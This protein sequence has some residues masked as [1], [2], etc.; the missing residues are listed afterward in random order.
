[1]TLLLEVDGDRHAV[2]PLRTLR[3]ESAHNICEAASRRR[4]D[5]YGQFQL[6]VLSRRELK[7]SVDLNVCGEERHGVER[8]L[9]EGITLITLVALGYG[10]NFERLALGVD[11]RPVVPIH[12]GAGGNQIDTPDLGPSRSKGTTDAANVDARPSCLGAGPVVLPEGPSK[13]G[14]G[15]C[16]GDNIGNRRGGVPVHCSS[17]AQSRWQNLRSPSSFP[18]A[19]IRGDIADVA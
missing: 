18:N 1:M 10:A 12:T 7:V 13:T 16:G 3:P 9:F 15:C 11:L 6:P 4:S 8:Q 19:A 14:N 17:I 2:P 5:E